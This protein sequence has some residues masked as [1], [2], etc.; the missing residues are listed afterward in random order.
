MN[1]ASRTET[2]LFSI[3]LPQWVYT[4]VQGGFSIGG[5]RVETGSGAR[6]DLPILAGALVAAAG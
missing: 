4:A 2:A 3:R 5:K 1:E 6:A